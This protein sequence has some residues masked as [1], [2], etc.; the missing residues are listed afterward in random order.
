ML[1]D[2]C[3]SVADVTLTKLFDSLY[4]LLGLYVSH[5]YHKARGECQ[6]TD[7]TIRRMRDMPTLSFLWM[8]NDPGCRCRFLVMVWKLN[9]I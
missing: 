1:Y 7:V 2:A 9:P 8:S 4:S 5:S 3:E 6:E